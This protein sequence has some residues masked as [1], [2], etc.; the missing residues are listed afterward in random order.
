MPDS[1]VAPFLHLLP[2]PP[3][4]L[5]LRRLRRLRPRPLLRPRHLADSASRLHRAPS[6][7]KRRGFFFLS[8]SE[9]GCAHCPR[10]SE[11]EDLDPIRAARW[12][13]HR[14]IAGASECV[15][16]SGGGGGLPQS[17]PQ[18]GGRAPA[19]RSG[20]RSRSWSRRRRALS[21]EKCLELGAEK[22]ESLLYLFIHA[23]QAGRQ[24]GCS[25]PAP[26]GG[27][28]HTAL[29]HAT[30]ATA[31]ATPATAAAAAGHGKQ[32][33]G[34]ERKGKEMKGKEGEERQGKARKGKGPG[35]NVLLQ[36][37]TIKKARF[38]VVNSTRSLLLSLAS[39]TTQS[40]VCRC[41][42]D[43]EVSDYFHPPSER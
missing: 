11:R 28:A 43:H 42:R 8:A 6:G 13:H 2:R 35:C 30:T 20:W 41:C 4:R 1:N 9:G 14:R 10:E 24:A 26:L 25:V 12:R 7:A 36:H 37:P 5:R 15:R 18:A 23:R 39:G 19:R 31:S 33:K 17:E 29:A 27:H 3:S 32:S 34:K 21:L 40:L 22:C 16:S 38:C